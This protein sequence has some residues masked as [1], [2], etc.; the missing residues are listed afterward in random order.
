M[1]QSKNERQIPKFFLLSLRL[2]DQILQISVQLGFD[3]VRKQYFSV[4]MVFDKLL[5]FN[6]DVYH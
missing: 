3:T 6:K 4:D 5:I 1:P 2:S